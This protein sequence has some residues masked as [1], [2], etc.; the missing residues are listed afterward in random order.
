MTS[1]LLRTCTRYLQSTTVC[2]IL[3]VCMSY[4]SRG[5]FVCHMCEY[6]RV[7]YVC[8]PAPAQSTIFISSLD[9][10][11]IAQLYLSPLWIIMVIEI[12][13]DSNSRV[14]VIEDD[15]DNERQ[16]QSRALDDKMNEPTEKLPCAEDDRID[17]IE[18]DFSHDSPTVVV[19]PRSLPPNASP[20]SQH[21]LSATTATTRK[22]K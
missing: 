3:R 16:G 8:S 7:L 10:V 5:V 22:V 9:I 20:P 15:D 4:Q 11:V 2:I 17:D 14:V 21:N 1:A 6:I 12:L 18:E 13:R 19:V